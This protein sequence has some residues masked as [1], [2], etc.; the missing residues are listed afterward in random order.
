MS[1]NELQVLK[2]YVLGELSEDERVALEQRYFSDQQV[3][4]QL[5]RIETEI[6]DDY[7]RG[8]LSAADRASFERSYLQN[9]DRVRRVKFAAALATRIDRNDTNVTEERA[10]AG[11]FGQWID[12]IRTGKISLTPAFGLASLLLLAGVVWLFMQQQS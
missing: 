4:D 3:F 7:V 6:V 12:R 9:P 1:E 2:R 5:V 11:F 10:S 8:R